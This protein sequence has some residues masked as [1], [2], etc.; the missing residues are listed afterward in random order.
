[1]NGCLVS[2]IKKDYPEITWRSKQERAG[3]KLFLVKLLMVGPA[4]LPLFFFKANFNNKVTM[5]EHMRVNHDE[6]GGKS[7][8]SFH[9]DDIFKQIHSFSAF[10]YFELCE[11]HCISYFT[12]KKR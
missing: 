9:L 4:E 2:G 1:M 11:V 8:T 12:N 6:D 7:I 5:T 3:L 10:S